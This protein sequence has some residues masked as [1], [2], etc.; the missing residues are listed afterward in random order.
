MELIKLNFE[1]REATGKE[2]CG[3]MRKAG[4]IPAVFYGPEYKE[5]VSVK[6]KAEEIVPLIKAGT[7]ETHKFEV[8]LPDGNTEMCLIRDVARNYVN[9]DVLHLDFYQLVKGHKI[10]VKVPVILSGKEECA[11][12]KLGGL[13]RQILHEI[14]I[15]VL[16][17][18]IPENVVLDVTDL[19][20]GDSLSISDAILPE[21]AESVRDLSEVVVEIL[22]PKASDEEET[23]EGEEE[24]VA[25]AVS[26]EA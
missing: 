8:V 14:E 12:F 15:N 10:N 5:A 7:W 17:I 1:N 4:F 21:S 26:P 25:E 20:M 3:R 16:P 23:P 19:N 22:V 2:V 11:G 24:V 18:E 6:V 9:D 13:I